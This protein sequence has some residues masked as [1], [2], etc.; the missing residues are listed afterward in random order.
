MKKTVTA[1][2]GTDRVFDQFSL[3]AEKRSHGTK[4][5]IWFSSCPCVAHSYTNHAAYNE[6]YYIKALKHGDINGE[7]I[8]NS[9][10]IKCKLFFLNPLYFDAKGNHSGDLTG[11]RKVK[12]HEVCCGL[13]KPI[14]MA[15]LFLDA[16]ERGHDG[17][18]VENVEDLG[19]FSFM[20][21]EK[22]SALSTIYGVV[23][24]EQIVF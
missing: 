4:G 24:P 23:S 20:I 19:G 10:I 22:G 18:I 21:K 6:K 9:S 17:V 8:G 14:T 15:D 1:Y 2:H 12:P 16:V 3:N 13:I 7:S 11:L 5:G